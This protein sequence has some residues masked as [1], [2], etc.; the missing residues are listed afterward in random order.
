MTPR[1]GRKFGKQYSEI[2]SSRS[3]PARVLPDPATAELRIQQRL[4]SLGLTSTSTHR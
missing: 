1:N 2:I 4:A 3:Y